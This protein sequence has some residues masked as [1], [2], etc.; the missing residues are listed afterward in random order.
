MQHYDA[1]RTNCCPTSVRKANT[2]KAKTAF[3]CVVVL[4]IVA[5]CGTAARQPAKPPT[6]AEAVPGID[7]LWEGSHFCRDGIGESSLTIETNSDGNY[8]ATLSD[9]RN[10]TRFITERLSHRTD[11]GLR[12]S[13]E[14]G[15]KRLHGRKISTL[16]GED[17]GRVGGEAFYLNIGMGGLGADCR[18]MLLTKFTAVPGLGGPYSNAEGLH[19]ACDVIENDWLYDLEEQ[20]KIARALKVDLPEL[21]SGY[22]PSRARRASVYSVKR[23]QDTFGILPSDL[24][25]EQQDVLV[26]QLK[27][28]ALLTNGAQR[29]KFQSVFFPNNELAGLITGTI[30][31]YWKPQQIVPLDFNLQ[32]L[33]AYERD[34]QSALAKASSQVNELIGL[35]D[36][37]EIRNSANREELSVLNVSP[38]ELRVALTPL[39]QRLN[40]LSNEQ[41]ALQ[42]DSIGDLQVPYDMLPAFSHDLFA[43]VERREAHT[44]DAASMQYLAGMTLYLARD[45]GIPTNGAQRAEAL[46]FAA[47]GALRAGLGASYS[48]PNMGQNLTEMAAG[49]LTFES[50]FDTA[51]LLGCGDRFSSQLASLVG[52]GIVTNRSVGDEKSLFVRTCAVEFDLARCDCL[53]SRLQTVYPDIGRQ[54]YSRRYISGTIDSSPLVG[55][56][57]LACGINNY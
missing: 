21:L 11:G 45:C 2:L 29:E 14:P 37:T 30:G 57:I 40:T 56:G 6:S 26:A 31:T 25:A 4:M 43:K 27:M 24:T 23:F 54:E 55:M 44:L 13:P 20:E 47:T 12:F 10:T 16:Y 7:G 32:D 17:V 19:D 34:N 33:D 35:S 18:G 38:S 52:S 41:Y 9:G 53:Q 8:L 15:A 36:N 46:D 49:Q 39:V 22:N 3:I 51:Q 1:R 50:G 48:A 5:G 28:C 42:L